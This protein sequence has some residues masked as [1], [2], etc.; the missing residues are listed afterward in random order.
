MPTVFQ[1][2]DRNGVPH[3][4]WRFKYIDYQGERKTATGLPTKEQTKKLAN[5][6]QMEQDEIRNGLRPAPKE[7]D[8]PRP[9]EVVVA[10]YLAWGESQGG[11]GGRPWSDEHLKPKQRHLKFWKNELQ[12]DGLS[13]LT[14][15]LAR[16]EEALRK[17]QARGRSGKTIQNYAEALA[18]LCEWSIKRDYLDHDPLKN[19]SHFDTTPV[20]LRRA[21]TPA[22]IHALLEVA[23]PDRRLLYK[24]A[25]A[26]GL[27]ANEL[28][29]LRV[30]HLDVI[31]NGLKLEAAWTKGRKATLQP[32][33]PALVAELAER[34]TGKTAADPLFYVPRDSA[35]ML[36]R[37]L[38]KAGIP[39]LTAEGK[40]DFHALRTGFTTLAIEV[41][42]NPKE[43]QALTRHS[44]PN[45]TMN[46]YARTRSERLTEVAT[47]IGERILNCDGGCT[48]GVQRQVA[49]ISTSNANDVGSTACNEN[50]AAAVRGSNPLAADNA[51]EL[52]VG[53]DE[54]HVGQ[55]PLEPGHRHRLGQTQTGASRSADGEVDAEAG[56]GRCPIDVQ[57]AFLSKAMRRM[58]G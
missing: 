20:L 26:S 2:K 36:Y 8:K 1:T 17:L 22:E 35:R 53:M 11:H 21:P 49:A 57:L 18:S 34:S 32:I 25:L 46:V 43:A 42:A 40:F 27:R 37:D 41:G 19:L 15:C 54:A 33:H 3:R 56:Q 45:L 14:G 50:N 47:A 12:L 51:I 29:S 4:N 16:V 44:T 13:D 48:T 39:R 6:I 7:S 31:N 23:C 28:R 52:K 24:L 30:H 58:Q 9:F 10:E 55:E 5:K 38:K